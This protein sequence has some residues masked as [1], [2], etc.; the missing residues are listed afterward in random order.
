MWGDGEAEL[1]IRLM[2]GQNPPEVRAET[3]SN[4]P[5][6]R[7]A[8]ALAIVALSLSALSKSLRRRASGRGIRVRMMPQMEEGEC[9]WDGRNLRRDAAATL[10]SLIALGS[11]VRLL[12]ANPIEV[13]WPVPRTRPRP[14]KTVDSPCRSPTDSPSLIQVTRSEDPWTS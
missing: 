6:T 11:R 3:H 13:A 10:P 8:D 1:I 7:M 12:L 9:P 14:T 5:V 2:N 4:I